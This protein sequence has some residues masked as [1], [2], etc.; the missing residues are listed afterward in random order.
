MEISNHNIRQVLTSA[1]LVNQTHRGEL[2]HGQGGTPNAHVPNKPGDT[3]KVVS[4]EE[5]ESLKNDLE[6]RSLKNPKRQ[7]TK[8]NLETE[9]MAEEEKEEKPVDL[10]VGFNLDVNG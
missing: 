7:N 9:E 10:N 1:D 6:K 8:K 5:A 2:A 3:S 4:S